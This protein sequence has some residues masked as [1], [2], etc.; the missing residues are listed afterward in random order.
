MQF[1]LFSVLHSVFTYSPC[2]CYNDTRYEKNGAVLPQMRQL[3]S[4]PQAMLLRKM[5]NAEACKGVALSRSD[6]S[7][8]SGLRQATPA[9]EHE[10]AC[11]RRPF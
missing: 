9:N 10:E 4:R 1:R 7:S 11:K 2:F 3:S 8:N 6:S 5:T